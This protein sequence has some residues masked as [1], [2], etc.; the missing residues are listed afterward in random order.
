MRRTL[1][2]PALLGALLATPARADPHAYGV[3]LPPEGFWVEVPYTLGTHREQVT[4]VDGTLHLDPQTLDLEGGRLVVPLDAFRSDDP[5]R[6][7]HLR[8]AMGLD[9]ARSRFPREHVCDQMNRLPASGP[10]AIA[11]PDVVLDLKSGG[12]TTPSTPGGAAKVAVEGT[13]R[14]H[15]VSRPIRFELDVEP[16]SPAG[17]IRVRGR[18]PLRLADFG[19]EVKPAEVLFVKIAVKD[20]VTVVVDVLLEPLPTS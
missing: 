18:I 8:E 7:C 16:A 9:Y 2:V 5:K 13:I 19:I 12:S 10:D 11:F 4:A 20:V 6:G 3:R 1:L 15:G 14:V 17:T